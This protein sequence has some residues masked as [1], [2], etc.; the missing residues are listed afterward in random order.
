MSAGCR[1]V[2]DGISEAGGPGMQQLISSLLS[3]EELARDAY[4]AAAKHFAEDR[5]FALFL[6]SLARDETVHAGTLKRAIGIVDGLPNQPIQA[7]EFSVERLACMRDRVRGILE[8][9]RA[10]TLDKQEMI[11]CVLE[12]EMSE[13]NDFFL[14]VVDVLKGYDRQFQH[15][16]SGMQSH[17]EKVVRFCR[18]SS[19][20]A[21]LSHQL[22]EVPAVWTRKTL[23]VDDEPAITN[24]LTRVLRKM[25]EIEVANDGKDA[26][27]RVRNSYYDAVIADVD[28][29]VVNGLQFL[30]AASAIDHSIKERFVFFSA[31]LSEED[32]RFFA[33]NHIR[34]LHKPAS[35]PSIRDMLDEILRGEA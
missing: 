13:W 9:I 24:M 18:M 19:D 25:T 32:A 30:Q 28:M 1:G 22:S 7:F 29:P 15:M 35:V 21:R 12:I 20:T 23:V 8:Q 3:V 4:S 5:P 26:I 11:G 17:K 6:G 10:R 33:A 27:E 34:F 31:D 16:A 14:Y 2:I